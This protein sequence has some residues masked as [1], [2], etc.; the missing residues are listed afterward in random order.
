VPV[1]VSVAGRR[2]IVPPDNVIAP[3]LAENVPVT[4]SLPPSGTL[5]RPAAGLVIVPAR[6]SVP[7]CGSMRPALV[8]LLAILPEPSMVRLLVMTPPLRLAEAPWS[9]MSPLLVKSL[10]RFSVPWGAS[11][12]PW[13]LGSPKMLPGPTM[14][15]SA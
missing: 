13:L 8:M 12:V 6:V 14:T 10:P 3:A 11:S 7:S 9:S 2:S 4:S 1:F 15:P 5:I